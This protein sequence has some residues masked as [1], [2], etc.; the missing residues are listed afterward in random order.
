MLGA[1]D[2]DSDD[3]ED[4]GTKAQVRIL[5]RQQVED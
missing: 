5:M 4:E 2:V 1:I 3:S